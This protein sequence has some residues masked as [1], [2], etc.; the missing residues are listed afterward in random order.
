MSC[1]IEETLRD[2]SFATGS[3]IAADAFQAA[4]K[5]LLWCQ[6][7]EKEAAVNNFTTKLV[8]HLREAFTVPSGMR[9]L[10]RDRLWKS[11]FSIRSSSSFIARWTAFLESASVVA[12]PVLYQHLTDLTFRMLIRQ[13]YEIPAP[14]HDV[15]SSDAPGISEANAL[16]YAAGYVVRQVSRK[17]NKCTDALQDKLLCC[18]SKLLKGDQDDSDPGTAEEWTAMVD[19][20]G[21]WHVRETTFQLFCAFE[22]ETQLYLRGLCLPNASA[23]HSDFLNKLLANEDIKFYWCIVTADFDVEDTD[24]HDVLLRMIAELYITIRG[25]SFASGWIEHYKQ[26]QKKSTQRSKSLRRKLYTDTH[27]S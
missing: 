14:A 3:S 22:E 18:A 11:F 6:D 5:L 20:G 21:L 9:P 16:R 24:I 19:R 23:L 1:T 2:R 17:V 4:R 26:E 25:F 27:L 15:V 12:T 7:A 13:E 8:G 10:N